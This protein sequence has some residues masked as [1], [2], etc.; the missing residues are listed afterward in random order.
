MSTPKVTPPSRTKQR[1]RLEQSLNEKPGRNAG[2]FVCAL[3]VV[4]ANART[5]NPRCLR[6]K[7]AAAPA[8]C[9]TG[10]VVMAPAC[11]LRLK[12]RRPDPPTPAKPWRRR[13][14]GATGDSA[15]HSRRH[16]VRI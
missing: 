11:R 4:L 3:L 5:Y 13:I 9:N 2:L 10:I 7:D 15:T 8:S 1:K 14:A 12:L 16:R 6:L